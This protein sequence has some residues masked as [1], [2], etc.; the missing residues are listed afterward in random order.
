MKKPTV[1]V[2]SLAAASAV[3]L[4]GYWRGRASTS[5]ALV[6]PG[7]TAPNTSAAAGPA[8]GDERLVEAIRQ[9]D[10]RVAALELKQLL[11][12]EPEPRAPAGALGENEPKSLDTAA[13]ME[14]QLARAA[15]VEEALRT[16]PRDGAWAPA[17]EAQLRTAVDAAGQEGAQFTL[18]SVRCLTSLC[19]MVLSASDAEQ[20]SHASLQLDPRITG[21]SRL[22]MALPETAADGSAT[23]TY[24]MFREG[25]PRPDEGT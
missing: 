8:E 5:R 22:V 19:E 18:K 12:K 16:E 9:L 25:Y 1:I 20:F 7:F 4:G 15:A 6:Q 23:V 2:T 13:V 3:A 10:R 21:M 14:R 11:A 17:T 24:R